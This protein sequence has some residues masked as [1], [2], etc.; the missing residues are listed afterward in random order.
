MRRIFE[1]LRSAGDISELM[2][3]IEF[4]AATYPGEL[5]KRRGK[6]KGCRKSSVDPLVVDIATQGGPGDH[7]SPIRRER[8]RQLIPKYYYKLTPVTQHQI[9]RRL[10]NLARADQKGVPRHH[11]TIDFRRLRMY[12]LRPL[13][14]WARKPP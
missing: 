9:L 1:L 6:P 8:F 4:A 5:K 10:E 13:A 7:N 2:E 14:W 11:F 12:P 3:W